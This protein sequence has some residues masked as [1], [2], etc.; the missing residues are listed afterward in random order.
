LWGYYDLDGYWFYRDLCLVHSQHRRNFI[1]DKRILYNTRADRY[2]Y[3]FRRS[4]EWCFYSYFNLWF[5]RWSTNI[6]CSQ[7]R[8]SNYPGCKRGSR[9][10]RYNGYWWIRR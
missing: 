5:Y 6:Y 8:I 7:W 4:T 3:L 2:Y 9:R 10:R 1:G